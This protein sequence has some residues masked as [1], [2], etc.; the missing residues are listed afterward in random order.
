[1]TVESVT[2]LLVTGAIF[3]V[4]TATATILQGTTD[5]FYGKSPDNCETFY[6]LCDQNVEIEEGGDAGEGKCIPD[7]NPRVAA[8]GKK[9]ICAMVE[10]CGGFIDKMTCK[11][12]TQKCTARFY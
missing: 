6:P 12:C 3:L 2:A 7:G 1:M 5:V 4:V 10:S 11:S 8:G 9:M